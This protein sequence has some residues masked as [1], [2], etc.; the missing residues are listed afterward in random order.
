MAADAIQ[1]GVTNSIDLGAI[2]NYFWGLIKMK[3]SF[4]Y[5]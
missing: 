3:K 2:K 4:Q 5:Y 1:D